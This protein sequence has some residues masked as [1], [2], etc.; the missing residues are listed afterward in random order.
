M[1]GENTNP[2]K[3]P[4]AID[5]GEMAGELRAVYERNVGNGVARTVGATGLENAVRQQTDLASKEGRLDVLGLEGIKSSEIRQEFEKA[6]HATNKLF[7]RMNL[8]GPNPNDFHEVGVDFAELESHYEWMYAWKPQIVITPRRLSSSFWMDLYKKLARD[9][10][11]IDKGIYSN[12]AINPSIQSEWAEFEDL[13]LEG[14]PNQFVPLAT[15]VEHTSFGDSYETNWSISVI[16]GSVMP[17]NLG[18]ID[19]N[20]DKHP[21]IS[22]YL[23]LQALRIQRGDQ[24][25]DKS[26]EKKTWLAGISKDDLHAP[27]G[28][29][30]LGF[31]LGIARWNT[32]MPN[33]EIGTRTPKR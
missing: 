18:R 27:V 9:Q 15:T 6:F 31:G 23:S 32:M 7:E 1:R 13:S 4:G 2:F 30:E 5:G 10:V 20:P 3:N 33:D 26:G 19:I 22:E 8:R 17:A 24:P 21:G 25:L 29:W 14:K 12:L 11:V 16:P 28:Y